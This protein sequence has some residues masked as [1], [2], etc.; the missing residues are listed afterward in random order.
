MNKKRSGTPRRRRPKPKIP[1]A[2]QIILPHVTCPHCY[3]SFHIEELKGTWLQRS[4]PLCAETTSEQVLDGLAENTA[5]SIRG[6]RSEQINLSA[7]INN[8]A[9]KIPPLS[10]W[11]QAPYKAYLRLK[12]LLLKRRYMPQISSNSVDLTEKK[13]LLEKLAWSRYYLSEWFLATHILPEDGVNDTSMTYSI[14]PYYKLAED[15]VMFRL[16]TKDLTSNGIRGEFM[17][18]EEV[19]KAAGN[20]GSLLYMARILPNLYVLKEKRSKSEE[21]SFW[22]QIDCVVLTRQC[23]F[24]IETKRWRK[25]ILTDK[26]FAHVY[27]AAESTSKPEDMIT[28][29]E[30]SYEDCSYVLGQNS[31]HTSHF[32]NVCSQ[33]PFERLYEI[34]VF[35][36]PTAFESIESGFVDNVFVGMLDQKKNSI[37]SVMEDTCASLAPILSDTELTQIADRLLEQFGDLNQR[38]S[39]IHVERI[40]RLLQS[41]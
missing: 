26:S 16:S 38:R 23:A 20:A 21:G 1:E 39:R 37:I 15:D 24:I 17:V 32:H 11:W 31:K 2:K 34:T 14:T 3:K 35:V 33:Y 13:A 18:F 6:L 19:R 9:R 36:D 40:K 4:C 22:C 5:S 10:R 28:L 41:S 27:L 25:R 7:F 30:T 8:T 12:L 29:N